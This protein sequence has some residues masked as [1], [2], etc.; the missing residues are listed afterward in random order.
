MR[1]VLVLLLLLVGLIGT[2]GCCQKKDYMQQ[3]SQVNQEISKECSEYLQQNPEG[4]C[5]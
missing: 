1:K 4:V 3:Q 2:V 5:D